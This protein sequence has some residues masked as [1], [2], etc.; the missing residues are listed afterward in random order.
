MAQFSPHTPEP[1]GRPRFRRPSPEAQFT[2]DLL[3]YALCVPP[4]AILG[5]R[6]GAPAAA[7]ARQ[8][9]MYL[10]YTACA[11]SLADVAAAVGRDRST[12]SHGLRM[13]E[14]RREDP[15]FDVWL[16]QL[17][18]TVRAAPRPLPDYREVR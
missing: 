16:Q 4:D 13:V 14:D 11:M 7:Q 5:D 6:R 12:V 15:R 8:V 9:A 2:A 3:G 17:E 18:D 10:L 1:R